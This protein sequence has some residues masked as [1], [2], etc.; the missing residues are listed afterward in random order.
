[1]YRKLIGVRGYL[2]GRFLDLSAC[3]SHAFGARRANHPITVLPCIPHRGTG[4]HFVKNI[5]VGNISY[6]TSEDDLESLFAQHGSVRSVKIIVDRMTDR[7]KGF[8]FV[9]MDDDAQA[10]VAIQALNGQEFMGRSLRVS[11]ARG[12]GDRNRDG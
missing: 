10:D 3:V 6:S 11:E 2:Y 12:R 8:G 4:S 5:Y 9:E 7:S 1:M